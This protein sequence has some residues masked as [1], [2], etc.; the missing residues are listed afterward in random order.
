MGDVDELAKL[1]TWSVA[2][3]VDPPRTDVVADQTFL[4]TIDAS[5]P[6]YT[7]WPVW[8]D[9]R[10]FSD[11]NAKPKVVER[12]WQ[13]LIVSEFAGGSGHVDFFRF[14]PR[15]EFS[16]VRVLQD[17]M[18]DKVPP[19]T[20]L[21]PVLVILRVAEAIAVGL[22]FVKELGWDLEKAK[23]GFAFKWTK[24]RGRELMPWG[25]SNIIF[26][27]GRTAQD[28][29]VSTFIEVTADTPV[30]AIAPLVQQAT[31][32]LFILFDGFTFPQQS[33]NWVR[34]L[35]ERKL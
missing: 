9:T 2:L 19:G 10:C 32:D 20:K 29:E 34:R 22:A 4:N 33:D 21:D 1:G 23:L 11:Q 8:M 31:R 30:T 14:D 25:Q 26:S 12:A 6:N 35:I 17:D 18:T 24:L 27:P 3:A 15:G 28:D 13:A 16:L 5:N 7:G